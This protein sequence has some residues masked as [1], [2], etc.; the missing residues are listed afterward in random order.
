MCY[1][2]ILVL[3]TALL[4]FR[5]DWAS[6]CKML[7]KFLVHSKCSINFSYYFYFLFI[8]ALINNVAMNI[9]VLVFIWTYISLGNIPSYRITGSYG[10]IRLIIRRSIRLFSRCLMIF[11]F[12]WFHDD[13]RSSQGT[14]KS[15]SEMML[16]HT[17]I[18]ISELRA[19][20][21]GA[22]V[23]SLGFCPQTCKLS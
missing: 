16:W 21:P 15:A 3:Y 17:V 20:A 12:I 18:V 5:K 2:S 6:A 13:S 11:I 10:S 14:E 8:L 1:W 23:L 9:C 7:S 19:W 4:Y 22:W